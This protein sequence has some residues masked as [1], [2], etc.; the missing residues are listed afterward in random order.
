[1]E[2][3]IEITYGML[4]SRN[5]R[6][7]NYVIDSILVY[8]LAIAATQLN[9]WYEGNNSIIT[10]EAWVVVINSFGFT[11]YNLAGAIIYYGF[12]ESVS[13]RSLGKYITNTKVVMRDGSRPEAGTIF[14]RT[15]CRLIPFEIVSFLVRP[16]GWHDSLSKTLVVD[17]TAFNKAVNLKKSFNKIGNEE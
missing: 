8:V 10:A 1:M 16:I 11:M 5:K 13:S 3:P 12:L 14:L 6:F 9:Y 17:V 2:E 4:A 7:A 15:I